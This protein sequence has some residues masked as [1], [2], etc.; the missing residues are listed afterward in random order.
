MLWQAFASVV[1][2]QNVHKKFQSSR[3]S[4]R[5]EPQIES[6]CEWRKEAKANH[7]TALFIAKQNHDIATETRANV[8]EG[9]SKLEEQRRKDASEM[10]DN[11][12]QVRR[13]PRDCRP[14]VP[15]PSPPRN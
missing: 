11:I 5:V 7:E 3:A 13:S 10:R 12:K 8:I 2:S 14:S 6:K 4:T 15:C 1:S 9:K